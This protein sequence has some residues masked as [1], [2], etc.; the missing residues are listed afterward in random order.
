MRKQK[1][2][3]GSLRSILPV[4][5]SPSIT[6]SSDQSDCYLE[7]SRAS[8][9]ILSNGETLKL[10]FNIKYK[11]DEEGHGDLS[12]SAHCHSN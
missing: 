9:N 4:G 3:L 8:W 10:M 5:F 1:A 2:D 7:V 6:L 12:W 11:S